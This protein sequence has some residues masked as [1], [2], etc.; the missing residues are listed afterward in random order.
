M[1]QSAQQAF[2]PELL[3]KVATC[4][5]ERHSG[6]GG[7]AMAKVVRSNPSSSSSSSSSSASSALMPTATEGKAEPQQEEEKKGETQ[8]EQ[9]EEQVVDSP[10][11]APVQEEGS[12][13]ASVGV[14]EEE[15][16]GA[17]AAEEEDDD[18]GAPGVDIMLDL[19]L[20]RLE[21]QIQEKDCSARYTRPGLRAKPRK[22]VEL[23]SN[24]NRDSSGD[25]SCFG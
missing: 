2:A 13:G 11:E 3:L 5:V 9:G 7:S 23:S 24:S 22:G 4:I 21:Q 6:H 16:K 17:V 19:A 8:E 15:Q 20:S 14:S 10:E 12:T 18:D 25:E 1:A